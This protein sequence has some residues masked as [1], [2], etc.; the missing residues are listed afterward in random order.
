[1]VISEEQPP[2]SATAAKS[3][4][5]EMTRAVAKKEIERLGGKVVGSVSKRTT[6]VVQ[7]AKPGSKLIKAKKLDV[8][9]LTEPEFSELLQ[10]RPSIGQL[11]E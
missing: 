2:V 4:V 3:N 8:Q 10:K 11:V 6:Y 5:R 1:M 7:G 9:I